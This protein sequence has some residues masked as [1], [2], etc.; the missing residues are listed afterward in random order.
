MALEAAPS[1]LSELDPEQARVVELRFLAGL[2]IKETALAMHLSPR[3]VDR[4]W[5]GDRAWL[6]REL[7]AQLDE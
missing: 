1:K 4:L 2:D 7:A 6:R 3:T 5:F